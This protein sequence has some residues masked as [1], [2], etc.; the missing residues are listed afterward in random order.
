MFKINLWINRRYI[1]SYKIQW[2]QDRWWKIFNKYSELC[3][4][5]GLVPLKRF[6]CSANLCLLF[7]IMPS[8]E[9]FTQQA[10]MGTNITLLSICDLPALHP[11]SEW[12]ATMEKCNGE[13]GRLPHYSGI[14][15]WYTSSRIADSIQRTKVWKRL[16]RYLAQEV[17]LFR[18]IHLTKLHSTLRLSFTQDTSKCYFRRV[19]LY[20][21]VFM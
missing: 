20:S 16:A 3:A 4:C 2:W 13:G 6:H 17:N 19:K 21:F 11:P 8:V 5:H 7:N 9:I 1:L 10:E 15:W 12:N 18:W 14:Y